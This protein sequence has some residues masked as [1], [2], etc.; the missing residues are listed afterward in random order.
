MRS[1]K[2]G[3]TLIE[4]MIVVAIIG[5]LAAIA[6]PAYQNYILQARR[7]DAQAVMLE[8]AQDAERYFT[9]NNTYNGFTLSAAATQKVAGFYNLS[10]GAIPPATALGQNFRV[11][12]TPQ[13]RQTNDT[14]GTLTLD[15]T[16][17]R[18]ATGGAT[19]WN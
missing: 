14:C 7:A 13:G 12:A 10:V 16:G 15:S 1:Y 5:I 4:V 8:V 2:R 19:C 9:R 17:A 6:L 11:T 18:T 3:F